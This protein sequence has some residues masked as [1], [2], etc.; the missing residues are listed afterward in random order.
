MEHI[1]V[2]NF[3]YHEIGT[4]QVPSPPPAIVK[5]GTQIY[6]YNKKIEGYEQAVVHLVGIITTP[7]GTLIF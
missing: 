5:F 2:Y 3:E 7:Q 4:F 1:P 6:T